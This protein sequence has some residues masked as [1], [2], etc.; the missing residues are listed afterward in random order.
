MP[1]TFARLDVAVER[2]GGGGG[3]GGWL[4]MD[5]RLAGVGTAT[6][7]WGGGAAAQ[8]LV[9]GVEVALPTVMEVVFSLL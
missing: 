8:V 6:L 3:G 2:L 4:V 7:G 9:G 5:A 1:Y